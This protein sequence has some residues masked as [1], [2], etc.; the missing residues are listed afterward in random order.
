M[1]DAALEDAARRLLEAYRGAGLRLA[2]A[3]ASTGGL[4]SA[5]LTG[6][7]GASAVLERAVIPYSNESKEEWLGVPVPL[8]VAHGAVSAEVARAMAE[9][10]LARS[11]ADVALA[12]TGVA[13]PGGG[14]AAKPVG[15]VFLALARR[16]RDTTVER[17]VFS[18]ER[19]EIQRAAAVRGFV[20]LSEQGHGNV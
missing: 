15:L 12:E 9:G 2:L 13:G 8:M 14:T 11:R 5:A 7:S 20:L 18:G 16:G 4:M 3:E 19:R 10:L 17:Q 6:I 1:T